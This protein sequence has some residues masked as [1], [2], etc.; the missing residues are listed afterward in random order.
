M[1]SAYKF[2][3][4]MLQGDKS[5]CF[6]EKQKREAR[7]LESAYKFRGVWQEEARYRAW[8]AT[9]KITD[10]EARLIQFAESK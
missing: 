7:H 6:D 4:N 1:I 2:E 9:Q 5:G 10:T 8:A 3:N